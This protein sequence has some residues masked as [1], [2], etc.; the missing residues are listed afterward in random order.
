MLHTHKL[1]TCNSNATCLTPSS[2]AAQAWAWCIALA[3]ISTP[4]L[5]A[6][7]GCDWLRLLIQ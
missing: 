7:N 6:G 2:K 3:H 1:A 4:C 5:Q